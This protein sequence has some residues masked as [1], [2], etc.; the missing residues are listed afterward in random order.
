[1][2]NLGFVGSCKSCDC[3]LKLAYVQDGVSAG[4]DV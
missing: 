1:V 4:P 3:A 2:S